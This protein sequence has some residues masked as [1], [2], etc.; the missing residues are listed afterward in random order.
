M[1]LWVNPNFQAMQLGHLVII[2]RKENS[3]FRSIEKWRD[4][5]RYRVCC[6]VF[7]SSQQNRALK[8]ML[9]FGNRSK[10]Q[11]GVWW[12]KTTIKRSIYPLIQL[13]A[14]N[15]IFPFDIHNSAHRHICWVA[16]GYKKRPAAALL[17][18]FWHIIQ[19]T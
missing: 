4:C 17:L 7:F 2:N 19:Q 9:F 14:S 12:I 10:H 3:N 15:L 1:I 18:I 16:N 5:T 13:N 11:R 6:C 8:Y